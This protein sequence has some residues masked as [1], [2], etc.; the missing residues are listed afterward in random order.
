MNTT[1]SRNF[2]SATLILAGL[3]FYSL[4]NLTFAQE[5]KSSCCGDGMEKDVV[6]MNDASG[7]STKK[8]NMKHDMQ[9]HSGMKN[10]KENIVREGKIDLKA[11]DK[12][13]DGKVFQCPMDWNVIADASGKCTSCKMKLKEVSL[14]EAKKNLL[15]N[16]YKVK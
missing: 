3:M 5:H 15:E 7:D 2:F 13:K 11:I 8:M 9:N 16:D 10:D 12:N 14:K 4:S 6:A 1:K